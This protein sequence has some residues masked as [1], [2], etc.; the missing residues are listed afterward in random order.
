MRYLI[1]VSLALVALGASA[2]NTDKAGRKSN[3]TRE[4]IELPCDSLRQE[5]EVLILDDALDGPVIEEDT[6]SGE[7]RYVSMDAFSGRVSPKK[8]RFG[9][10]GSHWAGVSFGYSGMVSG[11]GSWRLPDEAAYLDQRANSPGL[12]I[13]IFGL[14]LVS[15]RHFALVTGLGLEFNNYRFREPMILRR[16]S[17]SGTYPDYSI[18]D[19]GGNIAKSKLSTN[20]INIPLLAEFRFGCKKGDSGKA[21]YLYAGIV[22][23]WGYNIHSKARYNNGSG[24]MR[25]MKDHNIGFHN[26]RYGYTVGIGYSHYGL[27]MQ[28]YPK[29]MFK[30]GP[31]VRQISVGLSLNW[32]KVL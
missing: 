18:H 15:S 29:P 20:Y 22:G 21:G 10:I 16:S 23:G 1:T 7:H 25:R 26:F 8:V 32:G 19:S 11:L 13:N 2:Q 31:E 28:Y 6:P 17:E 4:I 27:Y 30:N 3:G 5:R 9:V 24:R 12:N 14:E